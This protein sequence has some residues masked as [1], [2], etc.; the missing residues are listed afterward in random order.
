MTD[1][2]IG[3]IHPAKDQTVAECSDPECPWTYETTKPG[4]A[5]HKLMEHNAEEHAK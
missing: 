1:H 4:E 2:N 5:A 3:R